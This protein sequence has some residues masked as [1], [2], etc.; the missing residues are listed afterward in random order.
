MENISSIYS[1]ER[2][3]STSYRS[4]ESSTPPREDASV[5]RYI[6]EA[7]R[8]EATYSGQIRARL[9][10]PPEATVQPRLS[11]DEA[12][13]VKRLQERDRYVRIHEGRH[14]AALGAYAGAVH[15]NY[16]AGPDNRLYAVGGYTEVNTMPAPTP[17]AQAAKARIIRNAALAPGAVSG[18]DFMV[19]V[20]AENSE[21]MYMAS[22]TA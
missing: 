5:D 19:A 7:P 14:A 21:R 3:F 12:Q 13:E 6:H 15:Y 8:E 9:P 17:E 10:A 11:E 1:Q 18:A 2:R 4:H 20:Q 22:A 16:E